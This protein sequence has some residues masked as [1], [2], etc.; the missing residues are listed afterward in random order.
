MK[1]EEKIFMHRAGRKKIKNAHTHTHTHTHTH[2]YIIT[3][4]TKRH[5]MK[6]GI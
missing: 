3:K 6:D 4:T 2:I 5:C 1:S